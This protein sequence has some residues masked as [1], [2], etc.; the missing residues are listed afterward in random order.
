M[1]PDTTN[2]SK[3]G[4]GS[5]EV[6]IEKDTI[7]ITFNGED[8]IEKYH[9]NQK[10][11]VVLE[12]ALDFFGVQQNRHTM[13]LWTEDGRELGAEQQTLEEAAVEP[14]SVLILR[15]SAVKGGACL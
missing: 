13:A 4:G 10:V 12:H 14:E 9:A 8:D 7:T 5:V 1:I 2:R 11:H 3:A 6:A 15:P